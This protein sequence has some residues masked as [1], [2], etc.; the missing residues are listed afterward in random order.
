M[1]RPKRQY[2]TNGDTFYIYKGY[3]IFKSSYRKRINGYSDWDGVT[4]PDCWKAIKQNTKPDETPH[5][6][7]GISL[8]ECMEEAD[9]YEKYY[10]N[11][12]E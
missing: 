10:D 12:E 4:Y 8:K 1:K 2:D 9:A 6:F 11:K 5:T 3:K 7:I